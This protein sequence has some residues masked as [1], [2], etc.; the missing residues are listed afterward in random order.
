VRCAGASR[1]ALAGQSCSG[2]GAA[3]GGASSVRASRWIGA[4]DEARMRSLMT[5]K[6]QRRIDNIEEVRRLRP[7][8]SQHDA[9]SALNAARDD[10]S[11]ACRLL[12]QVCD[13]SARRREAALRRQRDK[14]AEID[15]L[16]GDEVMVRGL[17]SRAELN[18]GLGV[19]QRFNAKRG[20]YI[21]LLEQTW[22]TV[23]VKGVCRHARARVPYTLHLVPSR[24][25]DQSSC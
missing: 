12:P 16:E 13:D 21:V 20:R 15:F 4:M 9:V 11:L 19:V 10:V 1:G 5:P 6:M 18:G 17:Q 22:T 3:R 24:N 14:H 7:T 25:A 2:A 8:V 23:A